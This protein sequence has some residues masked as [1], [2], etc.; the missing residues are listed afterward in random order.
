MIDFLEHEISLK[1]E[2]EDERKALL[3]VGG[4]D[5]TCTSNIHVNIC[6]LSVRKLWWKTALI[7][8]ER[9]HEMIVNSGWQTEPGYVPP[10]DV[11]V[12]RGAGGVRQGGNLFIAI[13]WSKGGEKWCKDEDE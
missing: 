2:A 13:L 3:Q 10:Q 5:N 8:M 1:G 4:H 7:R 9:Y 6:H 11:A 12:D